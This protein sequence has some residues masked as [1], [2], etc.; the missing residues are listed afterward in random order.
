MSDVQ[1]GAGAASAPTRPDTRRRAPERTP[2]S[3]LKP[4]GGLAGLAKDRR[5]V[6][7]ALIVVA[8]IAMS[9]IS[10]YFLNT[11]NLLTLLQ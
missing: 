9:L 11:A 8:F 10:P 2:G 7:L 5:V 4:S 1:T 6:L 3:G